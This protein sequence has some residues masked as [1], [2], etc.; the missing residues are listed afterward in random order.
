MG[1]C[2]Q[3]NAK[4]AED[5]ATGLSSVRREEE[6]AGDEEVVEDVVEEEVAKMLEMVE[7]KVKCS[8]LL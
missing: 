6:H 4:N 1:V 5:L 7:A 2:Q 3:I 8:L